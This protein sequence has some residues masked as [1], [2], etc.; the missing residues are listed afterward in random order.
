M[1]RSFWRASLGFCSFA[2]LLLSLPD[3]GGSAE[4]SSA[5]TAPAAGG[6][7]SYSGASSLDLMRAIPQICEQALSVACATSLDQQACL[8]HSMRLVENAAA[9]GCTK[10]V[11]AAIECVTTASNVCDSSGRVISPQCSDSVKKVNDC[12]LKATD[13]S[14][15]GCGALHNPGPQGNDASCSVNCGALSATCNSS[16]VGLQCTCD[17]GLAQGTVFAASDCPLAEQL[18][19]NCNFESL[20]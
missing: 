20:L 11:A 4:S 18:A 15:V 16:D 8:Y 13:W 17:S 5:Q 3:C 6:G 19:E 2:C 14:K 9:A 10:E 7:G 12:I 1:Y